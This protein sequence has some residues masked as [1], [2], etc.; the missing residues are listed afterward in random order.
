MTIT[1]GSQPADTRLLGRQQARPTWT[2]RL[3]QTRSHS[4]EPERLIEREAIS[5][6]T[7]SLHTRGAIHCAQRPRP[8]RV[9][10]V[11]NH[12]ATA[13]NPVPVPVVADPPAGPMSL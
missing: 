6:L 4:G 11:M 8:H 1:C 13:A 5:L 3:A 10:G 7:W 12:A 9:L 2:G